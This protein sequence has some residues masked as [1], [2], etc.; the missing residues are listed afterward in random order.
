MYHNKYHMRRYDVKRIIT[1]LKYL[2][3]T[4]DL[5]FFKFHDT[6]LWFVLFIDEKIM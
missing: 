1:E 5:E 3:D 4:Y 2:K 6:P